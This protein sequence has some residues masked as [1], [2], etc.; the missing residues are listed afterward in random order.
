MLFARLLFA[1]NTAGLV[2]FFRLRYP[3]LLASRPQKHT[4][5]TEFAVSMACAPGRAAEMRTR[6]KAVGGPAKS[7][8]K[9][10]KREKNGKSL[11]ANGGSPGLLASLEMGFPKA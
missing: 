10:R 1:V 3:R 6:A 11:L 2:S 8:L 7:K 5:S 9:R 4:V